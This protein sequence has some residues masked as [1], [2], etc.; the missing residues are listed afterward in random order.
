MKKRLQMQS[1]LLYLYKNGCNVLEP[2]E[3]ARGCRGKTPCTCISGRKKAG[4]CG[5][6]Q[7]VTVQRSVRKHVHLSASW[8]LVH[9]CVVFG[10]GA[11]I[12][13]F[14]PAVSA[15]M[16]SVPFAAAGLVCFLF[17]QYLLL[18]HDFSSFNGSTLFRPVI[19]RGCLISFL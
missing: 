7:A 16:M 4:R 13:H 19:C 14:L 5:L 3:S 1:L 11:K 2:H 10:L 17:F 8:T 18:F 12:L 9:H 15:D 6:A